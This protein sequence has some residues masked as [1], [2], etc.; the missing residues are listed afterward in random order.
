VRGLL[1]LP[2]QVIH[3]PALFEVP[4]WISARSG[5]NDIATHLADFEFQVFRNAQKPLQVSVLIVDR[6]TTPAAPK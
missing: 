3:D 4:A 6:F 1:S 5:G 2:E